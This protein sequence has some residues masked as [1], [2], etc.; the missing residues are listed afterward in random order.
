MYSK[1]AN[2]KKIYDEIEASTF[3]IR[4]PKG[5]N[6]NYQLHDINDYSNYIVN[7][8]YI[9]LPSNNVLDLF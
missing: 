4:M 1:G 6:S 2:W 8:N 9:L 3:K 7:N 5:S